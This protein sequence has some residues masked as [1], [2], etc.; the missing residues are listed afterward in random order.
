MPYLT[1]Q[2]GLTITLRVTPNAKHNSIQGIM[3]IGD[4]QNALKISVTAAPED[5]KANKAVIALLAKHLKIAKSD[6]TL[7]RG[8]TSRIK[9]LHCIGNP[10][11]LRTYLPCAGE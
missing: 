11:Q 2:S 4:D 8:N 10:A 6:I 5:N 9:T 7:I 1:T 3:P